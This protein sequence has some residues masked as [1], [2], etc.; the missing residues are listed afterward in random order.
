MAISIQEKLRRQTERRSERFALIGAVNIAA[1]NAIRQDNAARMTRV[2]LL[3]RI[4][5]LLTDHPKKVVLFQGLISEINARLRE[6][7]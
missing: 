1:S 3:H 4:D 2:I 5:H 6:K 7:V